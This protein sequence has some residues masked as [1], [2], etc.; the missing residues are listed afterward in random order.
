[1]VWYRPLYSVCRFLMIELWPNISQTPYNYSKDLVQAFFSLSLH[2][3]MM[4]N[5]CTSDI[6]VLIKW[7]RERFYNVFFLSQKGCSLL[8][9]LL[10]PPGP[11]VNWIIAGEIWVRTWHGGTSYQLTEKL[12]ILPT[13][14][15]RALPIMWP[16]IHQCT[17][18]E[19]LMNQFWMNITEWPRFFHPLVGYLLNPPLSASHYAQMVDAHLT[20][21]VSY[22]LWIWWKSVSYSHVIHPTWCAGGC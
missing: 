12:L 21:L 8:G 17:I 1:M 7:L 15:S 18:W 13:I 10:V 22:D 20:T 6:S 11:L 3:H 5:P 19:G 9:P 2:L 16:I 4:N 14:T